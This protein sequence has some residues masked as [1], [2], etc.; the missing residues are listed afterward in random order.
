MPLTDIKR[1]LCI[2][3]IM[4]TRV[5]ICGEYPFL[6]PMRFTSASSEMASAG[7]TFGR[8]HGNSVSLVPREHRRTNRGMVSQVGFPFTPASPPDRDVSHARI[9]TP[10]FQ[11]PPACARSCLSRH[12]MKTGIPGGSWCRVETFR[13]PSPARLPRATAGGLLPPG[14]GK[15]SS[16]A[17]CVRE[18]ERLETEEDTFLV[19]DLTP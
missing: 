8:K 11:P 9:V 18:R 16:A 19:P 7:C 1:T 3:V 13:C 12:G 2:H 4:E 5:P 6:G 10:E 14:R 15:S 17:R